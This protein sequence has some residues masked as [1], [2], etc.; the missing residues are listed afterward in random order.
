MSKFLSLRSDPISQPAADD[1]LERHTW[2]SMRIQ[3]GTRFAS[4][5]WDRSLEDERDVLDIP[6]FSLAEWFIKNWWSLF[7]ELCPANSVPRHRSLGAPWLSWM[8]RHC[9]RSADSSLF[10]PRLFVYSDGRD[11]IAESHSDRQGSLP[12]MPGEFLSDGIVLIDP[13]ATEAALGKFINQTLNR[14]DGLDSDR[15]ARAAGQWHAIQNANP[16]ETEFC[17]LAGRM[18]LDPYD[19]EEVSDELASFF[20]AILDDAA[21]PLVRD[22]TEAA[23]PESIEAE[24]RWCKAAS[25]ELRLGPR[26]VEL[27]FDL[28][29]GTSSPADYGYELARRVRALVERPDGPIESVE[30]TA[31]AALERPFQVVTRNHL[32][33]P[34]IK[35]IVGQTAADA[36]IVAAPHNPVRTSQRFME[37]RSLFHAIATSQHG[38]RLVTGAYSLDQKA[39]RAFAAELLAPG[40]AILG[41]LSGSTADPDTVENLSKEFQVSTYVIEWQL[42]N[43]GVMLSSD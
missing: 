25:E 2:C 39:S 21:R 43:M 19:P 5:L 14:V 6:A 9:L 37:A 36:F 18:G 16:E 30:E 24:W 3:V 1:P 8:K 23:R 32:P 11:L 10:L 31:S 42:E 22:L 4:R 41:K 33:G 34:Q 7:N 26:S 38:Q 35:S 27:P 13:G 15:V 29:V 40:Q 28:P 20:E 12:N 17:K